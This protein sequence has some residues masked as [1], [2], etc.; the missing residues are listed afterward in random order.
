[1]YPNADI[2]PCVSDPVRATSTNFVEAKTHGFVVIVL[3]AQ[4]DTLLEVVLVVVVEVLEDGNLLVEEIETVSPGIV[5][6]GSGS[7]DSAVSVL[8]GGILN[9]T[10]PTWKKPPPLPPTTTTP[11][12]TSYTA[13]P[14]TVCVLTFD[15]IICVVNGTIRELVV[16][17]LE[18]DVL[19]LEDDEVEDGVEVVDKE[20]FVEV[21]DIDDADDVDDVDNVDDF[22][23][24]DDFD[25]VDGFDNVDDFDD[26]DNFV[27]VVDVVRVELLSDKDVEDVAEVKVAVEVDDVNK[28]D[29]TLKLDDSMEVKEFEE[30][31]RADV[32]VE[33]DEFSTSYIDLIVGLDDSAKT[34]NA[35]DLAIIDGV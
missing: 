13:S 10:F 32:A 15:D 18:E 30:N 26:V 22:D 11:A 3:S 9:I 28:V 6:I 16:T 17:T 4:T 34:D 5:E 19:E 23:T 21:D 1:M 8:P 33:I 24:V 25:N 2:N 35:P 12:A 27:G 7:F 20:D 31:V 29:D 14:P